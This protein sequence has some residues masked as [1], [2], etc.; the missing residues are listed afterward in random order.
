MADVTPGNLSDSTDRNKIRAVETGFAANPWIVRQVPGR[1]RRRQNWPERAVSR[2]LFPGAVARRRDDD[3]SSRTAVADGLQRPNPGASDGP[4]SNAPLFGLAPDGVY[5][6][7]DVTAGTGELLPHPFTLV[8]LRTRLRRTVCFLWH[9]P[10]GR[11]R[12][13][14]GT[15][16]P[17]GARTFL[18]P[19]KPRRRR[20][21]IIWTSPTK[22]ADLLYISLPR[23]G[24]AS[25][26]SAGSSL[27]RRR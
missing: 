10:W 5:R 13:P 21:A 2:V 6:A 14:L 22:V 3:H 9:F 15:I 16:L 18:P 25:G 24:R 7:A 19:P 27:P 12:S 23:R 17:C 20:A 8:R 26:C 11:P 4:P 1:C